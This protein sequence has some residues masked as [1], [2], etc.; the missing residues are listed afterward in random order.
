VNVAPIG[1]GVLIAR[2]VQ[3]TPAEAINDDGTHARVILATF[4]GNMNAPDADVDDV[5][6]T[7]IKILVFAETA[8]RIVAG[9]TRAIDAG[10]DRHPDM[11]DGWLDAVRLSSAA[12]LGDLDPGVVER[13][14]EAADLLDHL[15]GSMN[16]TLDRPT[17]R[18]MAFALAAVQALH[19]VA[20]APMTADDPRFNGSIADVMGRAIDLIV[21]RYDAA[22]EPGETAGP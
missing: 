17:L 7:E 9:L 4:T 12:R 5:E 15:A 16:V 21:R 10:I 18:T 20:A 8:D 6:T 11:L 1:D 14:A 19:V 3:L 22:G 13:R 2:L